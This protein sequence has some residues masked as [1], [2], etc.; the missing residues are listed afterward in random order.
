MTH[1]YTYSILP[2]DAD[3]LQRFE[4]FARAVHSH[5]GVP[6]FS[7]QTLIELAKASASAN[8]SAE[9]PRV[10]VHAALSATESDS[11]ILAALV[12]ILPSE[13]EPGLLEAAVAPASRGEHLG[14]EFFES[15]LSSLHAPVERYTLWVHG[16][17]TD[18][19]I[20]SPADSLVREYSFAPVRT[21]FKMVLPL[22]SAAR[23]SLAEAADARTLPETLLSRT[24]EV[25][26]YLQADGPA[27]IEANAAAFAHHP[28]QGKLVLEDLVQRVESEWFRPEGFFI[29]EDSSAAKPSIAAYVWTKIPVGQSA[30]E[31]SPAGEIYVVG[32]HPN[33]Q[34]GGLGRTLTLKALAYLALAQDEQG[35][36]LRAI[37]LYVDEDNTPALTLYESLGFGVHTIDRMYAPAQP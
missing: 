11:T 20:I 25:Q 14:H 21:L 32:I 16:S 23:E 8:S 17:A 27:W 2:L 28:E 10:Y 22:D 4:A 31:Y 1:H 30:G 36:N 37:E 29:A 5:D 9:E 26:N 34:G 18:T 33:A 7:E 35:R 13:S 6:A 19:G 15:V 24:F 3:H 12:E